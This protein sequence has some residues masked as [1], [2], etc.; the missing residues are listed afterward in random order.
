MGG[1]VGVRI[2]VSV[3]VGAGDCV[4]SFVAVGGRDVWVAVGDEITVA[5]VG[6]ERGGSGVPEGSK[7]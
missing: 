2:G 5:T 4:G 6:V 1:E 3:G 7:L